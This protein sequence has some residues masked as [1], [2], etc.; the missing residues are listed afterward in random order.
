MA[1]TIRLARHGR[2]KIPFYRIV[3]A[4]KQMKRD[5]RFL[6]LIGTV[7]PL[8]NPATITLK[9]DRLKYWVGVGAKPSDTVAQY[10][11]IKIPG[12]LEGITSKRLTKIRATRAKRKA[13]K[14]KSTKKQ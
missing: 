5:G 10:V 12:Y 9:E 8:T 3:A 13:T 11:D 4:D 14:K 1:V 7:N 6:E 2:K